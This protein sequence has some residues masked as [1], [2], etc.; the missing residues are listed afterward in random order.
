MDEDEAVEMFKKLM[1]MKAM[2]SG[3]KDDTGEGGGGQRGAGAGGRGGG[4]PPQQLQ[5]CELGD[6]RVQ[7]GCTA[8]VALVRGRELTVANA[9]DSRAVLCRGGRAGACALL[10]GSQHL[11]MNPALCDAWTAVPL[12][13][14]HKPNDEVERSRIH[15][16]G[17]FIR[18]ANGHFR[19]NGNLNLS[20][21][22]G[23]LK[24]KQTS[25]VSAA[26]QM[27]TAQPDLIR[28]TI[29]AEDEFMVRPTTDD[30]ARAR[31]CAPRHP[32]TSTRPA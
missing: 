31:E 18:E 7:A 26:E 29:D 30:W 3:A 28:H 21:S 23:D 32:A 10:C 27:I 11:P 17:G 4:P 6:H 1:S 20:R 22:L 12:S 2:A 19:V 8:V 14:D 5:T 24:Y 15:K 9:G 16:A 25:S 13:F